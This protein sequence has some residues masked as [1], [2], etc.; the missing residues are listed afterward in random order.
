MMKA[1]VALN[2]LGVFAFDKEGGL[3]AR[4][5]FKDNPWEIALKLKRAEDGLI[6]EEEKVIAVLQGY[7]VYLEK[8]AKVEG[9][10]TQIPNPGG[11]K[12]R[13]SLDKLLEE[14]GIERN[15]YRRRLNAVALAKAENDLRE[16]FSRR[17]RRIIQG[18]SSLE[19]LDEALNLLLERVREWHAH[20]VPTYEELTA[21]RAELLR[22]AA[23][24][25]DEV[26]QGFAEA[27]NDLLK[28]RRRLEEKVGKEMA[29]VAPNLTALVGPL[30]GA[31]LIAL[32]RGLENLARMPGS[33]IQ[34]LGAGRAFFKGK[35]RPPKHGAIFQHPL[36]RG[37]PRKHR[38]KIARSLASKIAIAARVDAYSR[39]LIA[40]ELK[41]SLAERL[42][43][44]AREDRVK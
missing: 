40:D 21:D 27:V 43:R 2:V 13:K 24:G 41:K 33:R 3:L 11:E 42:E 25:K 12:L 34:I 1:Y 37:S 30:L 17:D 20:S 36:V 18:M 23:S 19:D 7:D 26:L 9:Y 28:Y 22:K 8:P 16:A 29:E 39:R 4:E 35:K 31:K 14:L 6:E 44:I 5:L 38:G 10:K 32:A 15:S